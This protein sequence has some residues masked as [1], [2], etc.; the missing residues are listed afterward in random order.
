MIIINN[1]YKP[2]N[3]LYVVNYHSTPFDTMG[4]F[5]KQL[6]F[7]TK[8]FQVITPDDLKHP[9]RFKN[10]ACLLLTFDDGIYNN[11]FAAIEMGNYSY[12]G[13]FFVVPEFIKNP[14][15]KYYKSYI[16]DGIGLNKADLKCCPVSGNTNIAA[17]GIDTLKYLEDEGHEIGS[18]TFTHKNIG[19][20]E[21]KSTIDF[22]IKESKEFLEEKLHNKTRY[23][24]STRNSLISTGVK[25]E[26]IIIKN[27]TH[28]FVTIPCV[29]KH[30][31]RYKI[32]RF[33]IETNWPIYR[34]CFTFS[35][36]NQFIWNSKNFKK[37]L[38][39]KT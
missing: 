39:Q 11:K 16:G 4:N 33:N 19:L 12:K 14:N 22:E 13:I 35:L 38:A 7:Y 2:K 18:H 26:N 36:L 25:E 24:A 30:N 10:R 17:M 8:Y 15:N 9:E 28:H 20:M 34:I 29:N 31:L 1:R 21:S 32:C 27:Y 6:D 5:I 3:G 37:I 23:F